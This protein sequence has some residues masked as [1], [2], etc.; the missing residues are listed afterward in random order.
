MGIT[1]LEM[2]RDPKTKQ[3]NGASLGDRFL[4]LFRV[5]LERVGCLSKFGGNIYKGGG[6]ISTDL[7]GI[8]HPWMPGS[9]LPSQG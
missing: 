8:Q 1:R 6:S 9:Q 2:A 3:I 4:T 7:K 5:M